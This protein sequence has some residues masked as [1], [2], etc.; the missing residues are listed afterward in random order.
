MNE[1]RNRLS[2]LHYFTQTKVSIA[3]GIM[4]VAAVCMR[5]SA[6]ACGGGGGQPGRQVAIE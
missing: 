5:N 6:R 2:S 4:T 1:K 3:A